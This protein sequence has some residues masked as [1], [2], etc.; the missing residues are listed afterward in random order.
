MNDI[1]KEFLKEIVPDK[2]HPR[3]QKINHLFVK[4][5]KSLN[6]FQYYQ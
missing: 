4:F 1:E 6:F 3:K 5:Y 2:T